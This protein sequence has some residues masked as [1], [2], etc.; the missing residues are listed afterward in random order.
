LY[1]SAT[2][3][4]GSEVSAESAPQRAKQTKNLLASG[5]SLAAAECFAA[6]AE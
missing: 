3:F 1:G 4:H 5:I 6:K 2:R